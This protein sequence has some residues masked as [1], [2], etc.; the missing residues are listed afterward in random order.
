MKKATKMKDDEISIYDFLTKQVN[1]DVM[2]K[3]K[4][5]TI[6]LVLLS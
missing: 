4:R 2:D 1:W 6:E 3:E 5:N